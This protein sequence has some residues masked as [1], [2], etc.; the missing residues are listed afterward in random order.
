MEDLKE[1]L[2]QQAE[3]QARIEEVRKAQRANAIKQ[4]T[5]LMALHDLKPADIGIQEVLLELN[6]KGRP[7]LAPMYKGPNGETWGG[8]GRRPNWLRALVAAGE[9]LKKLRVQLN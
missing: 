6:E 1:M 7:V 5:D 8:M 9:D 2:R 3:L 4:I